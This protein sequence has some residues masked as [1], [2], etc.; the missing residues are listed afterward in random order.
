MT[1]LSPKLKKINQ[2]INIRYSPYI[3]TLFIFI[4]SCDKSD[5]Y[6]F[7]EGCTY[8]SACNY[9][10]DAEV[11]DGSCLYE[12]CL[13]D[14]GGG[15]VFDE[16]DICNG[17]NSS[18]SDC[19]GIANGLSSL[20]CCGNCDMNTT[21]DCFTDD[22]GN[23][24]YDVELFICELEY[25]SLNEAIFTICANSPQYNISGFQFSLDVSNFNITNVSL[26]DD[27]IDADMLNY[28]PD[29]NSVLAFSLTSNFINS[30]ESLELA[31]F[32]GT[33]TVP[34]GSIEIIPSYGQN[35]S[36]SI[37]SSNAEELSFLTIETNWS[38]ISN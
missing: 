29:G 37:A 21:N 13:G 34:E 15:A 23:C 24:N 12:D 36:L 35:G 11:N 20:D 10:S 22:F 26:G 28:Y 6:I 5:Q 9:N 2:G 19:E 32:R 8:I 18:C 33:Y 4:F 38:D 27:A 3:F 25:I 30:G 16:C 31:L 1:I 14:C 17:D 7:A